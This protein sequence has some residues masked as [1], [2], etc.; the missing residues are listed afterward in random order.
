MT[1]PLA[2]IKGRY[3]ILGTNGHFGGIYLDF[4]KAFDSVSFQQLVLTMGSYD[5]G[6]GSFLRTDNFLNGSFQQIFVGS[7]LSQSV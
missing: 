3:K 6:E 4:C 1:R 7:V 5:I 2:A